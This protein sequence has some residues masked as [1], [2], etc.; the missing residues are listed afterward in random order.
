MQHMPLIATL[1][2]LA[3]LFGD[4]RLVR[5]A[6]LDLSGQLIGYTEGQTNVPGGQHANWRTNRA[7]VVCR[8]GAGRR[9][10][11]AEL[12]NDPD[13]STQ[14]V[15]WSPDGRTAVVGRGWESPENAR[16]EEEHKTFR[17]TREGW[18]YDSFLVDLANGKATNVTAVDRVSFYNTGLFFWRNNPK[19]LGF[20]AL[21]EGNSNP[22]SM[23]LDGHHKIDLTSAASGFAYGF[24]S[25]PDGTRIS[26]HENYQVYL[27]NADGSKRIHVKTGHPFNFV[28]TWSPD[29]RW[30]LFLS[31]EHYN[32]HPHIVRADGSGLKKLAD[33]N[34]YAG[35][36]E[37]LDT[38]SF[39]SASSD[40]PEWSADGKSIFYTAQ[41]GT[42][43]ELFQATL[44]EK[45]NQLTKSAGATLH[46]H[47]KPSP[48]G[49]WI[50]YGS[51]RDGARNLYVMRL[52][53]R[54]EH[55]I[56][57]LKPGRAAM[58]ASWQPVGRRD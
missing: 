44:D 15:G 8:D 37:V 5:P 10:L 54:S 24:S 30:V 18:L 29:G 53:N 11:A 48:D 23:D 9:M 2:V 39:H 55:P 35:V 27:A 4:D 57:T 46:Y 45:V 26:Y 42:N 12:T 41:S 7:H 49:K 6:E 50:A 47:P 33:R 21:I 31:G 38:P 58:H 22:F 40:T 13:A 3:A 34:G 28:P 36:I 1:T 56:T 19:K 52:D 16:W 25:S 20:T 32:C 51:K 43:V 14:F 17:F